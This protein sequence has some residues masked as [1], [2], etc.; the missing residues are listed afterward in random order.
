MYNTCII[1]KISYIVIRLFC[2]F[3]IIKWLDIG[4]NYVTFGIWYFNNCRLVVSFVIVVEI[5]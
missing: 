2:E 3:I 5:Y 1:I 4:F